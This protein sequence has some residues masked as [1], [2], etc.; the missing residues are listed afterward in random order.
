MKDY[1]SINRICY[2]MLAEQYEKRVDAPGKYEES[3]ETLGNFALRHLSLDCN[4]K[5]LVA[6]IGPGAGKMLRYFESHECRTVGIDLSSEMAKIAKNVSP[7][8]MIINDDVFNV[9]FVA[10]Q[11]DLIYMGAIIHLFSKNDASEL[12]SKIKHW[13]KKDGI[14]FINTT[15]CKKS[16]E[17]FFTKRDYLG[18]IKRFRRDWVEEEF[19]TF[20]NEA[21]FDVVDVMY[22]NEVDRN[23]KWVSY[24]CRVL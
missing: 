7:G 3:P 9:N 4:K 24:I 6:E 16:E 5:C 8:S 22:T 15:C 18:E 20:I 17:G 2:D 14:M 19:F 10:E 13:I 11:F 12:L 23:K 1:I 21:G